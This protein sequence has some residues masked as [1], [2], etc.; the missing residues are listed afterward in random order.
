MP[1]QSVHV[2]PVVEK[3][4]VEQVCISFS[5]TELIILYCIPFNSMSTF[6][7]LV[8]D[9]IYRLRRC[10]VSEK[11]EVKNCEMCS[12]LSDLPKFLMPLKFVSQRC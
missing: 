5:T 9:C 7:S 8:L 2:E 10:I 11:Y 4:C 1:I 6:P 3:D 12:Y